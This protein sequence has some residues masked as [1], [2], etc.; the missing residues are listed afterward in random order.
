VPS[1][2]LDRLVTLFLDALPRH[3][4]GVELIAQAEGIARNDSGPRHEAGMPSAV[5]NTVGEDQ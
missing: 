5:R 3:A 2:Q 4:F 1:K